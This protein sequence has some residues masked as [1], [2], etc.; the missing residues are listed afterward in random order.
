MGSSPLTRGKPLHCD[1]PSHCEGLIPAH[2]GKT[3]P[4]YTATWLAWAHPRSRGENSYTSAIACLPV[5]SSPLTRGKPL[6]AIVPRGTTGLIPAHAGK[7]RQWLRSRGRSEAHPRSRGEN[8]PSLRIGGK[9]GGSSPLTRGKRVRVRMRAPGRGLIPAHAGKTFGVNDISSESKA[10]PRSRGENNIR[11]DLRVGPEGSSPLTRG[12]RQAGRHEARADGL[13]P[14][15]AGKTRRRRRRA[16]TLRAHPRSR[17]ENG[18]VWHCRGAPGGSSPL[19]RGKLGDRVLGAG[20]HR[21]IPAHAGKTG[22]GFGVAVTFGAHP[23]SRGENMPEPGRLAI[24]AGSSPLT[25]G[26]RCPPGSARGR[27][28]LIPA[29]AGKTPTICPTTPETWAHPR[30]RGENIQTCV[31]VAAD[32]GSSPLTR[33]K[34]F[35]T[36]AFIAQIDQILESLELCAFSESYSSQDVYATD[37]PRDRVRSI[38]LGLRSSRGAS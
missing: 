35:L 13:I 33:G 10:H 16:R 11:A 12:K 5:G 7:T 29:H 8:T 17:G 2:A 26:K 24:M 30:S 4:R 18:P 21:L 22:S 27:S 32:L 23:R 9:Q 37:A 34:H 3:P 20:V 36:C 1:V 6:T 38:D 28:G 15:H 19:T 14:A 25:R 31:Q